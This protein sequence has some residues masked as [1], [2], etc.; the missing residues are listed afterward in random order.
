MEGNGVDLNLIWKFDFQLISPRSADFVHF[1]TWRNNDYDFS[2]YRSLFIRVN[3]ELISSPQI[4]SFSHF[5]E[6]KMLPT[7]HAL[8]NIFGSK[9]LSLPVNQIMQSIEIGEKAN[10]RNR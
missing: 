6:I 9:I 7:K 1:G 2:H 3:F 10:R 5:P 4:A 8:L